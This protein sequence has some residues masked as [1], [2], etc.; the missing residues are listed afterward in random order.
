M[1][2][3]EK[4]LVASLLEELAGS[5]IEYCHFKSNYNLDTA[6][7]GVGDLDLLVS[8]KHAGKFLAILGRF[9]F[10]RAVDPAWSTSPFV[11]HFYGCDSH[12]GRLIHLHV[13]LR[14]V[15][16]GT[17]YKNH[18]VNAESM[19]LSEA[20]PHSRDGIYVPSPETELFVFIVRKAIE[21][22]SVLEHLLFWKGFVAVNREFEWL[23]KSS[24]LERVDKLRA[25]WF[26]N[27]PSQ[28]LTDARTAM[29]QRRSVIARTIAG[30]RI[31]RCFQMTMAPAWIVSLKRALILGQA[32]LRARLRLRRSSR[33]LATGGRVIAFVGPDGA[34]KSTLVGAISD[35]LDHDFKV[36]RVHLGKPAHCWRT[37]PFW[38]AI[39]A[40]RELRRP[41]RKV[42]RRDGMQ[43]RGRQS[44]LAV[45]GPV[46]QP[47][48][49]M[50]W[51]NSIDR[52]AAV[53]RC[54]RLAGRG[55]LVICDRFPS[56]TAGAPDGPRIETGGGLL[57]R[58]VA[59]REQH[60]YQ[61]LPDPDIE[62]RVVAPLQL[63][64]ARNAARSAS[65]PE[66]V[67][68]RRYELTR[69]LNFPGAHKISIDTTE[70]LDRT[71]IKL[72][73]ALWEA[74]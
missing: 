36:K 74:I 63:T 25:Q 19:L 26:P 70:P 5:G 37:W 57:H 13:Y 34:G 41:L 22:T 15:T 56:T 59:A 16:G 32:Y 30:Y 48:P 52:L 39:D 3:D 44:K 43:K 10:R 60:N 67:M 8:S 46:L 7:Q 53:R 9:R 42:V 73:T 69:L 33:R 71:L 1:T 55:T 66:E 20:K 35:W 6:L 58:A 27:V 11:F 49:V 18:W 64:L 51:L 40:L 54:I 72:K 38:V 45:P 50:A 17:L 12:A 68:R 21:Q 2:T 62:V 28:L 47:H 14:L 61:L 23:K 4:P 24:D 31:R 65:E 29:F